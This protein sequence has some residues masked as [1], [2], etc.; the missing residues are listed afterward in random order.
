MSESSERPIVNLVGDKV[1]L[2][3]FTHDAFSLHVRWVNDWD[4]QVTLASSPLG[5]RTPETEA[6]WWERVTRGERDRG[7]VIY[8]REHLAPI[9]T[10]SL[11]G[12][13]YHNRR[14]GLGI[15]VG[16]RDYRG[17]GYGTEALRLILDYGFNGLGLHNISLWTVSYNRAAIRAYEKVGFRAV[18]RTREA[19][20]R[21]GKA[22]DIVH[23]DILAREFDGTALAGFLP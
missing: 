11:T 15:L 20:W 6:A 23:M 1:A 19:H 12:I 18:G 13:D 14:A 9:G 22:F 7:F 21:S 17:K 2:G 4:A 16:E 5:P 8:E 3:P 10:V